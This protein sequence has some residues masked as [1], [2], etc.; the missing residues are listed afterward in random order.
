[1]RKEGANVSLFPGGPYIKGFID[2]EGRAS[3]VY[4]YGFYAY[5]ADEESGL[6][7]IDISKPSNPAIIGSVDTPGEAWSIY[8]LRKIW[9][10]G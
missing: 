5:V 7:V 6:Q 10:C 1:M 3:D 4:V 2:T 9:I 8:C